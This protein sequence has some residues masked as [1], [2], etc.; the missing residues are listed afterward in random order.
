MFIYVGGIPGVGKTTVI[1]EVLKIAQK[2]GFPLQGMDERKV[3][4][5]LTDVTSTNKY[6]LLPEAIRSEGRQ[7]MVALFYELDR[8]NPKTIRLRD[9]HFTY[10][11]EDNAYFIRPC[12]PEDKIQ[13]L[14]FVVLFASPETICNRRLQDSSIRPERNFTDCDTIAYHQGIELR[15]A[16]SHA[17]R[18]KIPIRI[19]DNK[20]SEV[21][22]V[23][24]LLFSFIR[25]NVI[26]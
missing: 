14:A 7:R 1:G 4:Y 15:T 9:D 25:E 19:F 22:Q 12:I 11:K 8:K 20:D 17:E 6:R 24:Q 16:F 23:S 18:L 13:I 26:L 3:L 5:Q 10:L 2:T 21:T